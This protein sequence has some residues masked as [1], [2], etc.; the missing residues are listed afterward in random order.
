MPAA[1]L[2]VLVADDTAAS[3]AFAN[4]AC[5]CVSRPTAPPI[6]AVLAIAL[7]AAGA[8]LFE[9]EPVCWTLDTS[10][11]NCADALAVPASVLAEVVEEDPDVCDELS[12]DLDLAVLLPATLADAEVD[13][14][15]AELL[16]ALL[17]RA[18][19]ALLR[20]STSCDKTCPKDWSEELAEFPA[21][22]TDALLFAALLTLI[23]GAVLM[24]SAVSSTA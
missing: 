4:A 2:E 17:E 9:L 15:L 6:G 12:L 1:V 20:L 13:V 24:D 7:L 3:W 21:L 19:L 10:A 16:L 14:V 5:A 23:I 11:S 18:A 8:A 22:L